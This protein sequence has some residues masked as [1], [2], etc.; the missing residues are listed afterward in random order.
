MNYLIPLDEFLNDATDRGR[1]GRPNIM[2]VDVQALI[3]EI[4]QAAGA[5]LGKDVTTLAGFSRAQVEGWRARPS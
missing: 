2:P 3:G 5:Q 4:V 1:M